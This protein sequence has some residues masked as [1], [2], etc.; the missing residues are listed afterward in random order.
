MAVL[1]STNHD[2]DALDKLRMKLTWVP[3]SEHTVTF[4]VLLWRRSR[5]EHQVVAFNGGFAV[6]EIRL[7]ISTCILLGGRS[8]GEHEF[9]ALNG[10]FAVF[11]YDCAF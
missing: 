2:H 9:V 5:K 10:R 1:T 8:L 3:D 7:C 4:R 6:F 11:E